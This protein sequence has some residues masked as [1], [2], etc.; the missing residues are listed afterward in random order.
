MISLA[1]R[2]DLFQLNIS[3]SD[4]YLHHSI[5]GK[6]SVICHLTVHVTI[7]ALVLNVFW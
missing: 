5:E 6:S 2:K 3:D 7:C 4:G 1:H